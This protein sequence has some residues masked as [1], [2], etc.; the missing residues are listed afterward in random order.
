MSPETWRRNRVCGGE[1]GDGEE[2]ESK[3]EILST[4]PL[5]LQFPWALCMCSILSKHKVHFYKE[6]AKSRITLEINVEDSLPELA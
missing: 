2:H 3:R 1:K 6:N 4:V 5:L